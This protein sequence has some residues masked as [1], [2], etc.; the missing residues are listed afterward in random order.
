[1]KAIHL[2]VEQEEIVGM[3]SKKSA[4]LGRDLSL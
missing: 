1:M 4:H 2:T 3:A